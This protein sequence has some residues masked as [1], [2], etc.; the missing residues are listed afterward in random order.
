[1]DVW[2]RAVFGGTVQR[3]GVFVTY[4][5]SAYD[6]EGHWSEARITGTASDSPSDRRMSKADRAPGMRRQHTQETERTAVWYVNGVVTRELRWLFREQPILDYGIDAHAEI[7]DDD[8]LVSG[9]L[10]GLQIKGG[11][12]RFVEATADGWIFRD[13]AD[14]LAYWL[15]HSLR[16]IVLIVD[17]DGIPFWEVVNTS[18]VT[19][20]DKGFWILIPR[21]QRFD[22]GARA[23]LLEIAGR[24]TGL[25]ESLPDSYA[26]LPADAVSPLK[27]AEARDRLAAARLADRLATGRATADL[28]AASLAAA[29]PSWL[30]RSRAAQDLWMAVGGFAGQ[31]E[32]A[33]EAAAAFELAADADG[34]L[35][36]RARAFAGLS[37][38]FV[39]R[40]RAEAHLRRA[41]M[42]GEVL[43][44]DIGLPALAVPI[45]D[46]RAFDIP[47]SMLDAPV[48]KLNAE[49]AVLNFLAEMAVRTNDLGA[50]V[51]YLERAV[52]FNPD[53]SSMR[54]ALAKAI[55]RR[56]TSEGNRSP[57]DLRAAIGHAQ[58]AVEDRRRWDGPSANALAA[59]LDIHL[60]AG[61]PSDAVT[62]A[63]PSSAGGTARD[64]EA[65]SSEVARVGAIAALITNNRDAYAFFIQHIPDGPQRREVLETQSDQR[66]RPVDERVA[67]STA[68]LGEAGDDDGL[69]AR[70]IARL[71]HLGVWPAQADEMRARSVLPQEGFEI[72][73]AIYRTT[74][75][76]RDVGLAALRELART[77]PQAAV[78]LVRL[79][80]QELSLEAAIAECE[81]LVRSRQDPLLI[82]LLADLLR[83]HGDDDRAA[84]I[85]ERSVGNDAFSVDD[86]LSFCRWYV[87]HKA[88]RDD[89]AAA[90]AMARVG[91]QLGEDPELSWNLVAA[92]FNTGKV[93]EAREALAR[94]K[95]APS[96]QNEV[97]MWMHLH[98]GVPLSDDDARVVIDLL[99]RQPEGELREAIVRVLAREEQLR[100]EIGQPYPEDIAAAARDFSRSVD[101]RTGTG[102]PIDDEDAL[103]RALERADLDPVAFQKLIENVRRGISSV[104]DVA[105]QVHRPYGAALLH[106][107]AGV[108]VAADL[109]SALRAVGEGAAAQACAAGGCVADLSSL[110]LLNLLSEDER[111]R[112]RAQ[113]QDLVIPV[114]AVVDTVGT[115]ENMRGLGIATYSASLRPD[116]TIE[117]TTLSPA[118]RALLSEQAEALEALASSLVALRPTRWSEP[119]TD[120]ILLSLEQSLPLWCDDTALRQRARASGIATFGLL[121]LVTF[122]EGRAIGLD[123]GPIRRR[124]IEQYVVDLPATAED[125]VAVASAH[126][127]VVGPAH[128]VLARASWWKHGAA[129]WREDWVAIAT[130][131][132]THSAAAL[133]DVTRAAIMGAVDAVSGGYATQRYQEVVALALVACNEAGQPSPPDFLAELA[134]DLNPQLLPR[135][136]YVLAAVMEE[137]RRRGVDGAEH[138]AISLLPGVPF[139]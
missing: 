57:R 85:I 74:S 75:G 119:A 11:D 56:L 92:L 33:R 112:I 99:G 118:Q 88:K 4:R 63:L 8:D 19:E 49:P 16:V 130:G 6:L 17:S 12:S 98:L 34:A 43:L 38:L 128:T 59:L 32:Y 110:Y 23:R 69:A 61:N 126:G 120:T 114:S 62:A 131:A 87:S 82:V 52:Q 21:S 9:R 81:R 7:V 129:D 103:R 37:L 68:L 66:Q 139:P 94:Y 135:S 106:R 73:R 104:A 53:S 113:L 115:R 64:I 3:I 18:T 102:S 132:R 2:E 90:A 84:E 36:A 58:F 55:W 78:E 122:L 1:M 24:S 76:E 134:R 109:S 25:I 107:P 138:V 35:S 136:P 30:I 86:R 47:Q 116:G 123:S 91:L 50:A 111:L 29:K 96:G 108:L 39:D 31:H 22:D 14:H 67:I 125:L 20:T 40:E 137:L 71:V 27:R 95:P 70:C 10:L 28:T 46:A 60:T 5:G 72:F 65:T 97:R 13:N 89:F 101:G 41:H 48:A 54:L 42:E 45:N 83:R 80:E 100:R 121:D 124:L 51:D 133:V 79:V 93:P 44:A 117:R 15:G 105:D 77:S 127:W 26:L